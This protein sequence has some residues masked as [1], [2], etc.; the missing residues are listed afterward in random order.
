MKHIF[1]KRI[2]L[3]NFKAFPNL[4]ISF[5]PDV[6]NIFGRNESGKTTV[7]DAITWCLFNKDHLY[8]TAFAIKTH[9]ADGI[10]IP[11]DIE[12]AMGEASWRNRDGLLR[13]LS[14]VLY[15]RAVCFVYRLYQ[16]Y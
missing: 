11:Q 6:T 12:G 15:R 5:A 7:L 9:G 2:R 16:I 3:E 10:D 4:E 13:Q 8:R 14:G 1:F